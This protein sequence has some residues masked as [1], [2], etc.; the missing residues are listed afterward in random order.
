MPVYHWPV[1]NS[2]KT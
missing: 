1:P 2:A